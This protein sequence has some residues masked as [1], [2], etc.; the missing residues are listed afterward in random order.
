MIV[1]I[2]FSILCLCSVVQAKTLSEVVLDEQL[3]T[4]SN[5]VFSNSSVDGL[6]SLASYGFSKPQQAE[7]LSYWGETSLDKKAKKLNSLKEKS[8]GVNVM[9]GYQIW[10]DQNHEFL[11]SYIRDV[12]SKFNVSPETMDISKPDQVVKKV[13]SW[14]A[15]NTNNVI[16]EVINTDFVTRDMVSI[17][18]N[19]IY[20]KGAWKEKFN[21]DLTTP[22]EFKG[23]GLVQTMS[24]AA[25]YKFSYNKKDKV[26]VLDLPFKGDKYSLI[27]AM[28]A[29]SKGQ[30]YDSQ[31]IS[32]RNG[33]NIKKIFRDYI[34]NSKAISELEENG[35]YSEVYLD[36]PKFEIETEIKGIHSKLGSLGLSSLFQPGALTSMSNSNI[37]ISDILQKAKIIVNEEG[38]EAAAVTVGG[39]VT[40]S[41]SV[42]TMININGPFSYMI[43]NKTNNEKLFE[44]VVV[45]P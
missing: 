37:V 42:P 8:Q 25:D 39:V 20:F 31:E 44:G 1:K 38:A 36:I 12:K 21:K 34:I 9:V 29:S 15:K 45:N 19:A 22:K 5:Y 13:N 17:L 41:E 14:A 2:L 16:K 43:L 30:D 40:V 26:V 3:K 35:Y 18:A 23:A 33:K 10:L 28:S 7:L 32:Y 24:N 4:K 11:P 6:L 27:V